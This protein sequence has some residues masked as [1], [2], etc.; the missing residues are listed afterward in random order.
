MIMTTSAGEVVVGVNPKVNNLVRA[1]AA[2]AYDILWVLDSNI[3]VAPGTLAHSVDALLSPASSK[4]SIG[5]VH[6]VPFATCDELTLG[7]RIETAFLNTNHCKMY[8]A[9]NATE[10]DSCVVGKSNMYRKSHVDLLNGSLKP[11]PQTGMRTGVVGLPAFGRFLAED[12]MIA[13]AIWHELGKR[14][15]LSCDVAQNAVGHMSLWDYIWRRVRWIRVRKH[16]VLAPTLVEPLTESFVMA[17]IGSTS[18]SRLFSFP[19]WL[20]LFL[21]FFGVIA[22]DLDVHESLSGKPLTPSIRWPFFEA[23]LM[24]EILAL[25]I[26]CLAMAGSQVVWRGKTYQVLRHGEVEKASTSRLN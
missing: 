15:D 9:L 8:L 21:H 24:R 19:C 4:R 12:N 13:G 16:M 14:H 6:H 26:W 3:L 5:L 20:F 11:I 23:W 22:V 7:S 1:Y 25:P 10:I 18:L 17:L 2:A